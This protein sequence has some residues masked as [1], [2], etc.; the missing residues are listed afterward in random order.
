[1]AITDY[2]IVDSLTYGTSI[3]VLIVILCLVCLPLNEYVSTANPLDIYSWSALIF[4]TLLN[5]AYG[6]IYYL[7]ELDEDTDDD[8]DAINVIILTFF[9]PVLVPAVLGIVKWKD[10][11]WKTDKVVYSIMVVGTIF[12]VLFCLTVMAFVDLIAGIALLVADLIIICYAGVGI[13]YV[14]NDFYLPKGC[15]WFAI[16]LTASLCLLAFAVGLAI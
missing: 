2:F 15:K 1:M 8:N 5:F 10:N 9:F 7:A 16:I 6:I 4:G 13:V 12:T 11:S 14:N 3:A